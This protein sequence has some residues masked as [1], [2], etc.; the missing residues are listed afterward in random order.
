MMQERKQAVEEIKKQQDKEQRSL[1]DLV[2]QS[3]SVWAEVQNAIA[4]QEQSDLQ[5]RQLLDLIE[6]GG[7]LLIPSQDLIK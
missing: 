2:S 7:K 1:K 6:E 3:A 5:V 4:L